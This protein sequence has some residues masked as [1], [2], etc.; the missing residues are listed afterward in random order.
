MDEFQFLENM[1]FYQKRFENLQYNLIRDMNRYI[2]QHPVHNS[3]YMNRIKHYSCNI[4]I[5][6]L[7]IELL[8]DFN[9]DK[10]NNIFKI[11][12]SLNI[13]N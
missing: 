6:S 9:S 3:V 11:S 1:D 10:F 13:Y 2:A 7:W 8:K 12:N 4:T 5:T